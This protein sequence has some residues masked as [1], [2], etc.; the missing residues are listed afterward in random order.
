[1]SAN[2][3]LSLSDLY[4]VDDVAWLEG[5]AELIRL[6][7]TDAL[8]FP[9]LAEYLTDMAISERRQVLNRMATL[10]AHVLKWQYQPDRRSGS[11]RATVI[12]QRKR[13]NR[14]AIGVLRRH[15]ED[16]LAEAYADAVELAA[17]ETGLPPVETFPAACPYTVAQLL[18]Q[19]LTADAA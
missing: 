18:T 13:L 3:P 5:T 6:G 1:M 2:P 14:L 17:V 10:L 12:E 19:D 11:W 16:V 9:H 15:A 8:D 4:E 7:R